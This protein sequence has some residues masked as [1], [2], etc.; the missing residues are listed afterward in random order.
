[1]CARTRRHTYVLDHGHVSAHGYL[2]HWISGTRITDGHESLSV[3][4]ME[5]ELGF[6]ARSSIHSKQQGHFSSSSMCVSN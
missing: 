3:C 4:M 5:T 1:M 6:S 2:R